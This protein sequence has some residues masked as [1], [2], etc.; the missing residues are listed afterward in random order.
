MDLSVLF[1][2]QNRITLMALYTNGSVVFR[3]TSAGLTCPAKWD[4][5]ILRA[6][7]YGIPILNVSILKSS[8]IRTVC[9]ILIG[10][11]VGCEFS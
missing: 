2:F 5:S 11:F 6:F 1:C 3:S 7:L 9:R 4:S 10:L 8:R